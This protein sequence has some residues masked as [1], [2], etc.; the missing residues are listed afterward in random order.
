M[1]KKQ[2]HPNEIDLARWSESASGV[3]G[4]R[5]D[6]AEHLRWCG[7]CR[8]VAAG[9][10][11]LQDEV[12]ATLTLAADAVPVPRPRWWAVQE[13]LLVKQRRQ[14]RGWWTSAVASVVAAVCLMLSVSPMLGSAFGAA[15]IAPQT[16]PP[17][18]I[19]ATAPDTATSTALLE[20]ATPTPVVFRQDQEATLL[21][22]DQE[23]TLSPT[24][25][26]ALPPTPEI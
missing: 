19:I 1:R 5:D 25:V 24:P 26:L 3:G 8:S 9:H 2:I 11:W 10:R 14:V 23:G 18:A 4:A 6:V 21:L 22:H 13:A 20:L 12:S 15:T 17:V 7:R 16:A